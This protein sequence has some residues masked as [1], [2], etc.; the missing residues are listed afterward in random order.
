MHV[1]SLL[2]AT[3]RHSLRGLCAN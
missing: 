2:K 1:V 3:E